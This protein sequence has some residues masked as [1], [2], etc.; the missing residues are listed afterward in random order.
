MH[1]MKSFLFKTQCSASMM[2]KVSKWRERD[3]DD[4]IVLLAKG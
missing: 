1:E 4:D 3:E 2:R